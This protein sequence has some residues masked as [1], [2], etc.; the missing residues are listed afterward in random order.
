[1]AIKKTLVLTFKIAKNIM[2][3]SIHY[4]FLKIKKEDFL[5]Q[6]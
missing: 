6:S 3:V 2:V 4:L 1:M 5:K